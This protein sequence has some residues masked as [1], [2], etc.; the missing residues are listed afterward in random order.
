VL[1]E[2]RVMTPS[3]KKIFFKTIKELN[4]TETIEFKFMNEFYELKCFTTEY[5]DD[6]IDRS[7]SIGKL[8]EVLGER[9][10]LEKMTDK[11]LTFY[12]F[13][14]FNQKSTFKLPVDKIEI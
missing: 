5:G 1:K 2:I 7:Y 9:M 3:K 11:Y 8:G 14:L 6:K 4:D 12:T 13:N 10:N